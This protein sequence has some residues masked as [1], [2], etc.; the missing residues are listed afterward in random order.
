MN[1][2]ESTLPKTEAAMSF[3]PEMQEQIG[4]ITE[5]SLHLSPVG[6]FDPTLS[7]LKDKVGQKVI[8]IDMGGDKIAAA[9]QTVGK[10]GRLHME[11]VLRSGRREKGE[12]YL[13]VIEN[14]GYQAH[15]ADI[16]VGI[17][18]AGPISGKRIV[19]GPNVKT[20]LDELDESYGGNFE[21][22]SPEQD[23]L[24]G[25]QLKALANDAVA[26]LYA[27]AAEAVDKY[28]DV[29]NV[30]Y[31]IVGSGL[32][33]AVLKEGQVYA[34]EP[35]HIEVVP[36]LN[37]YGRTGECK[38]FD[39]TFTC[40]EM[41]AGSK[42]G[43]EK[44]WEEQTG[45]ELDGVQIGEQAAQGDELAQSLYQSSAKLVAAVTEG[46]AKVMDLSLTDGETAVVFHGGPFNVGFLRDGATELL[47][48][49]GSRAPVLFTGDFSENACRDGAALAALAA[50]DKQ[51]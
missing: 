45:T 39:Q 51:A 16:P 49:M 31:V 23:I 11:T 28:P 26:G 9:E 13:A 35:G 22:A 38:V 25:E 3:P 10:D 46:I 30:I 14:L 32:G 7:F 41:V 42:T 47:E 21:H 29:K 33:G 24:L 40:M 48:Q 36:S 8:A 4:L 19:D 2:T 1:H 43:I 17:S 18:Y 15:G 50:L 6:S 12:G 5:A 20:L 27:G 44:I 34:A 37:P